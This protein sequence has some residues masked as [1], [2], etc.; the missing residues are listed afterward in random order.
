MS[1]P[2]S[3]ASSGG[4]QGRPLQ[5]RCIFAPPLMRSDE[6]FVSAAPAAP[7]TANEVLPA[8]LQ[9]VQKYGEEHDLSSGCRPTS[10]AAAS[11]NSEASGDAE[12]T[13]SV[14]L[15]AASAAGRGR[16]H[17]RGASKCDSCRK[18]S[19]PTLIT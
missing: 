11:S 4:T 7:P 17:G 3:Q 1:A 5:R 2:D 9:E 14:P 19:Y 6:D 8:E 13:A 16:G 15:P 10:A 18:K 12:A